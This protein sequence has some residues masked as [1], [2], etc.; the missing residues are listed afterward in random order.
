[1]NVKKD[2]IYCGMCMVG[3]AYRLSQELITIWQPRTV[4]LYS[5]WC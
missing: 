4:G 5:R 3:F 2:I 1:M